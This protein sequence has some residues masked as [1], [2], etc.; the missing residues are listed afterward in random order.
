VQHG[1]QAQLYRECGYDKQGMIEA[2]EKMVGQKGDN[3]KTLVS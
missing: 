2:A 3:S 1:T